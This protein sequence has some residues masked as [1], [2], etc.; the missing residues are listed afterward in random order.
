[1]EEIAY[2]EKLDEE[3]RENIIEQIHPEQ[4]KWFNPTFIIPKPHWKW[5]KILDANSFNKEIQMILFRMIGTGEVRD[6]L[7]KGDWATSLDLKSAF[8]HL[9]V[10]PPRRPYLAFEAMGKVYQYRAMPFGTQHS[11]IF[12]PQALAMVLTKI[13]RESNIR[14]LNY[15]DDLRLLH[16][17]KERLRK[18]TLIIMKILEAFGWTIAQEKCEIEP[19]QQINFLEWTLDLKRMQ[20]KMIDIKKPKITLPIKE[21][22]QLHR[23]TSPIK[24]KYLAPIVGKLNFLRILVREASLQLKLMDSGKT[25]SLKNKKWTENMILPKEILQELYLLREVIAKNQE[26]TLDVRITEAV[27]ASGAS[28][29]GWGV[30]LELQTGDTLVQHGEW[31]K[32][33]KH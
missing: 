14:I 18:Q 26:M 19:K 28:L 6:L 9:I 32:E 1:V 27:M 3:L 22:Y 23:E 5:R 12:F 24:I 31:N 17:N 13:R 10:Y 16:Q 8:H 11:P 2:T 21:I 29:K 4:A 7:R 30:T 33:Q 20:L 15:V 25:R